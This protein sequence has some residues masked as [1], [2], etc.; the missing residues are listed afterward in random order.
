MAVQVVSGNSRVTL[1]SYRA[2]NGEPRS[3][4]LGALIENARRQG[5][6]IDAL[7]PDGGFNSVAN[8]IEME[9]QRVRYVMP[10]TGN[11]R[12]YRRM[13][14]ADA[15]PD[16]AVRPYAMKSKGGRTATPTMVIVP[17]KIKPCSKKCGICKRCKPVLMKDKYVAFLTNI[18]VDDPTE[19][20]KYLPKKYRARWGIETGYRSMESI[21][22]KTKSP[23]TATRPFLFYFTP[24]VVNMWWYCKAVQT[25]YWGPFPRCRCAIT[26]TAC[27]CA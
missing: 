3:H 24:V 7:L 22:A 23:K 2:A 12:V 17:K 13:E 6:D 19:L 26:W 14:A 10:K 27:G 5:A 4:Y 21:R 25:P 15:D 8:I 1:S 18:A 20:L 11:A 16:E 9:R